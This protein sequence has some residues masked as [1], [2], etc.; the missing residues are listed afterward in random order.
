MSLVM[1]AML[2]VGCSDFDANV[3]DDITQP[4]IPPEE[5]GESGSGKNIPIKRRNP[6]SEDLKDIRPRLRYLVNPS[7]RIVR[8]STGSAMCLSLAAEEYAEV[9]I[10][11]IAT[12][13]VWSESFASGEHT[14]DLFMVEE[15]ESYEVVICVDGVLFD[16]TI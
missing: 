9:E 5:D 2:A 1:V 15:G 16:A 10:R 6:T 4:S 7:L 8:C 3:G 13:E 14:F 11:S 12:G